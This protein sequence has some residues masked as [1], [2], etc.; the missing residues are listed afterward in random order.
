MSTTPDRVYAGLGRRSAPPS[1]STFIHADL[2]CFYAAVEVLDEPGLRGKPVVVGGSADGRGVVCSASYEA[3]AFGVRSA[4]GM[5]EAL[6][7]C[8]AA[9]R[10]PPRFERYHE[11]SE[12]VF[13]VLRASTPDVEPRSLDEAS[14][15]VTGCERLLG[16]AATIAAEVKRRVR[17]ELGLVISLGVAGNRSLAKLACDLGKPDG[18]LVA[19]REPDEIAAWLA[20]LAVEKLPGV[21]PK[22]APTL[23]RQGWRTLGQLAA[24]DAA[25]VESVLGGSGSW[26]RAFA[27]GELGPEKTTAA[28]SRSISSETTFAR[29]VAD[30]E[31]LRRTLGQLAD[32]VGARARADGFAAR[33][34]Q[35]KLRWSDFTTITRSRSLP[36]VTQSTDAVFTTAWALVEQNVPPGRQVRLL[37]VALQDHGPGRPQQTLMFEDAGAVGATTTSGVDR[38]LD[39]IRARLGREAITRARDLEPEV[40]KPVR[41]ERW[42]VDQVR[43]AQGPGDRRGGRRPE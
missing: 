35:V 5:G 8:P 42:S 30:R 36:E 21:G 16:D 43:S 7:R 18:L 25:E 3:R 23:H 11:L 38:A 17:A 28:R 13:D 24:A 39:A 15:D 12:R 26:W 37:G 20:P 27:R 6:R 4:M 2:D 40:Q 41:A 1:T 22:T 19:P 31:V 33:T 9:I 14:M 10:R 29:D 34:V 32:E